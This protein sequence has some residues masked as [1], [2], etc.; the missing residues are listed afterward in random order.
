MLHYASHTMRALVLAGGSG[1]RLR[2]I[3]H[4]S[5]KQLVPLAN[6]PILFY[7]LE[8]I[9]AAGIKEVGIIVGDTREEVKLACS[10]GSR[11]G[12]QITYIP[13]DEPRGLAHCVLLAR[14]FL[15]DEPFV[16]Y[17]GDNF[18]VGGIADFVAEFEQ[19]RPD[20]QILLTEVD[21]PSSF[22]IAQLDSEGNVVRLVEK[23]SDPPSNLALV[24]VYIFGKEIHTAVANVEPSWRG[25]LEITDAIQWLFDQGFKVRPHVITGD[26][27]DT[28]KKDDILE[29]NRIVLD[30]M[31]GAEIRGSVDADSKIVGRVRVDAG[32][33]I[34]R[35]VVRGPAVIGA[36]TRLVD[37]YIGPYSAISD[38]CTINNSELE[39]SI[40]LERSVVDGVRRIEESMI[41]RD[42]VVGRST[43][44]PRA[45]RL[46]LGDHSQAH[47]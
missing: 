7:C 11:W 22:G 20:A 1:T 10:D 25:E 15:E 5:A 23:P 44:Q 13:Q 32:A 21:N 4:T 35:S 6:K 27:I 34:V 38:D 2:P 31:E 40:V 24:G 18:L 9:A 39:H 33:E 3:T 16:M 37:S 42:V 30:S 45:V 8:A 17:L 41:G 14:E 12:L 47:L 43:D 29:A 19:Q 36:G 26:W 28:G 46:M